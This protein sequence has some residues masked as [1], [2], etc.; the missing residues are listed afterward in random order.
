MRAPAKWREAIRVAGFLVDIDTDFDV[1]VFSGFLPC[2]YE[3]N[4]VGF[5]YCASRLDAKDAHEMGAAGSDLV[6]TFTT[7]ADLRECASSLAAA[8]VL[9]QVSGGIL[10]DPQS[11]E[12][13]VGAAAVEW[14]KREL[15]ELKKHLK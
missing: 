8:S 10:I 6:V 3:G 13:F 2:K 4:L 11:G 7:H 15:A 1:D 9:C 12:S 14:A 5:E